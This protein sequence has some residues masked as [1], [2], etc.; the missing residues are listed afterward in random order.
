M[1]NEIVI[2]TERLAQ[3]LSA[4]HFGGVLINSRHNFAW[5]TGGKSNHVNAATENGASFLFVRAD[6][7]KFVLA[8]NIEMPRL[9]AEEISADDFE[10][11]EFGWTNEKSAG[12]FIFEKAKSLLK[13]Y[14]EITSDLPLNPNFRTIE[15]LTAPCR[16]SLTDAEIERYRKLGKD[17]GIALG[18]AFERIAPGM[19]ELEIARQTANALAEYNIEAVVTLVGADERIAK[20]RHPLPTAK[21]WKKVVLIGVCAR[22]AG[23]IASLSRIA[24]DGKI[25]T[26]LRDRTYA[27]ARV[28]AKLLAATKECATGAELFKTAAEAYAAENFAGEEKLHHQGGAGGYKTRDWVA[29]PQ[30]AEIVV[31]NQAFAW[32]PSI[33]GTKVEETVIGGENGIE[34]ITATPDFPQIAVK[35]NGREYLSPDI[36]SL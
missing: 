18:A 36:L 32:N 35:I 33:T 14:S 28:N 3:M 27:C 11:I 10:P 20:F 29:H 5:L 22:R 4:E 9:L 1:E 15:N 31:N 6:G 13:N 24:C 30:S 19:S 2:K 17:A 25:P 26:E 12:D 34:I 7:A 8:N 16:Y 21:I 23:L